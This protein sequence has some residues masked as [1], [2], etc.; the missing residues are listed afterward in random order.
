MMAKYINNDLEVEDWEKMMKLNWMYKQACMDWY[1]ENYS[2]KYQFV[3]KVLLDGC[4]D[5]FKLGLDTFYLMGVHVLFEM[6]PLDIERM[7]IASSKKG[8]DSLVE[9]I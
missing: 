1:G 2:K 9:R 6:S 8:Y 7:D 5:L 4:I 3:Y